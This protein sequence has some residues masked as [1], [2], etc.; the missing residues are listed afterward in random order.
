MRITRGSMGGL[1]RTK[2]ERE[3]HRANSPS[4]MEDFHVKR[5]MDN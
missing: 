3:M 4:E 5:S 1:A 2:Q